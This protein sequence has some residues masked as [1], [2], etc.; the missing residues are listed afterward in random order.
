MY[1]V[2]CREWLHL[3]G[4]QSTVEVRGLHL[5]SSTSCMCSTVWSFHALSHPSFVFIESS[6]S[7]FSYFCHSS[8]PIYVSLEVFFV[9]HC[10]C[11]YWDLCWPSYALTFLFWIFQVMPSSYDFCLMDFNE[12]F[13]SCF[14]FMNYSCPSFPLNII[15]KSSINY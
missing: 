15:F 1:F 5:T 2:L 8:I 9:I 14:Y 3:W 10:P 7:A 12:T 4:L 13:D 6:L 11:T